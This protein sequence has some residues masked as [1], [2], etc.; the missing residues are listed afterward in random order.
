MHLL[1]R[2]FQKITPYF[3]GVLLSESIYDQVLLQRK[4]ALIEL[5]KLERIDLI[6]GITGIVFS[7]DR[8]LQLYALLESYSQ[9]V[10]NPAPLHV[11]F[12]STNSSYESA[13]NNIKEWVNKNNFFH[14]EFISQKDIFS[15]VLNRLLRQIKT[16]TVFFLVDDN[17][18][19]NEINFDDIRQNIS[20][21]VII[22]L[23]HSPLIKESYTTK[24]NFS[25]P[26]FKKI[27]KNLLMFN[28][29]ESPCEWSDPWSVDGHFLDLA[30]IRV[31]SRLSSFSAPNSFEIALKA[32]NDISKQKKGY[33]FNNSKIIN[34]PINRVQD[35]VRNTSG[36]ISPEFLLE[37]W[38][39]NYS[40]DRSC[41]NKLKLTS[42]HEEFRINFKL[43][44]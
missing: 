8:P 13:Y 44:V 3:G 39:N 21:D 40:L 20:S 43:R 41:L 17:V 27:N 19:I 26:K 11:I 25:P 5:V 16:K 31:I 34:L 36:N 33:C 32:F 7:K 12:S 35:E 2:I 38:N 37:K 23:R 28:W 42:T 10:K 30:E 18:F 15:E 9:Y 29:F 24:Q 14:I 22:S 6:D 1:K 4:N